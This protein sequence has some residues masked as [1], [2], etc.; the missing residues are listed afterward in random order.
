[1]SKAW[2][3]IEVDHGE[4]LPTVDLFGT[5][6]LAHE[7]LKP[8][9]LAGLA[10]LEPFGADIVGKTDG[11]RAAITQGELGIALGLWNK[12]MAAPKN[13]VLVEKEIQN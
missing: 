4:D 2:A 13:F 3:L 12:I 10:E 11:V 8:R 7:S 6:A 5:K 1:M 9:L